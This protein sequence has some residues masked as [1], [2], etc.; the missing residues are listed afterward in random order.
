MALNGSKIGA[1]PR[2]SVSKDTECLNLS[3]GH[4]RHRP[5]RPLNGSVAHDPER[6]FLEKSTQAALVLVRAFVT[7]RAQ[8]MNAVTTGVKVRFFSVNTTTG[9]GRTGRA[10]GRTLSPKRRA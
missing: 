3:S 2:C 4:S 1:G 9:H 6:T 7:A 5:K 10:T 8:L